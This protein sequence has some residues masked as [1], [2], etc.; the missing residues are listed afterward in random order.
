[1]AVAAISSDE[2]V[3][4]TREP[5]AI[6][7]NTIK[8]SFGSVT[9]STNHTGIRFVSLRRYSIVILLNGRNVDWIMPNGAT[10]Y[11]YNNECQRWKQAFERFE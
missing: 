5:I 7:K 11:R 10:W 4:S 1:M 2:S 8:S 9:S 3:C 6:R